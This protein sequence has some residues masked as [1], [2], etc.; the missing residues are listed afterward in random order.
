MKCIQFS[1]FIF[2][3]LLQIVKSLVALFFTLLS[4]FYYIIYSLYN[5]TYSIILFFIKIDQYFC[6]TAQNNR[7]STFYIWTIWFN[8]FLYESFATC[9]FSFS[10]FLKTLLI[11][12]LIERIP[13][14]FLLS[15]WNILQILQILV[16]YF[17]Y[18]I[19]L[20]NISNLKKTNII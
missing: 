18:P 14:F 1:N 2:S 5:L 4:F 10:S 19:N 3:Q 11:H 7:N 17:Y 12:F 13:N 6:Y 16:K 15:Y 20:F 8:T 9:L